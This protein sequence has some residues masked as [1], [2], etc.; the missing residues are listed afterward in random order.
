MGLGKVLADERKCLQKSSEAWRRLVR[1]ISQG[2]ANMPRTEKSEVE[3]S[4]AVIV[5]ST[6]MLIA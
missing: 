4:E 1:H 6:I 5:V 2:K 3:K